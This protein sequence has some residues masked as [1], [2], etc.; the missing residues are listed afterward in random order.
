MS[1]QSALPVILWQSQSSSSGV[2]FWLVLL[3]GNSVDRSLLFLDPRAH[4]GLLLS[5]VAGLK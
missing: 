3:R 2:H 5:G 4:L 1:F